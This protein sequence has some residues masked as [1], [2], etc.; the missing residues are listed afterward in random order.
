MIKT[1][2]HVKTLTNSLLILFLVV[3]VFPSPA[4][5]QKPTLQKQPASVFLCLASGVGTLQSYD[6]GASP[7]LYRGIL[8]GLQ[9]S[10]TIEWKRYRFLG[11]FQT[12]GALIRN[13]LQPAFNYGSYALGFDGKIS[14]IYCFKK[15]QQERLRLWGGG[16]IEYNYDIKF[17]P[18]LMNASFC[19]SRF[20]N[21]DATARIEYDFHFRRQHEEGTSWPWTAFAQLS[22]PMVSGINRPGFAYMD[23]Y[24]SHIDMI[25]TLF[26]SHQNHF[27]PFAGLA[28]EIGLMYNLKN[29][30]KIAFSYS[31][32]YLSSGKKGYYRFDNSRHLIKTSF[33]FNLN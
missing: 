1:L 6:A 32:H 29:K 24:T 15:L 19:L 18:A 20:I 3:F 10:V 5:S 23:N 7:L 13:S 9:S 28:T 12:T 11:D 21:F 26:S 4:F 27:K 25:K 2:S 30:N 17:F 8:A 14:A 16:A 33:L 31:W 22:L